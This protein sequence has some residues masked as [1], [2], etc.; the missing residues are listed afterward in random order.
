MRPFY[1][2]VRINPIST[3]LYADSLAIAPAGIEPTLTNGTTAESHRQGRI[4]H[5]SA[6]FTS[7]ANRF[8]KALNIIP[9]FVSS[10]NGD[11]KKPENKHIHK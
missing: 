10:L 4:T 8:T 11:A 7:S 9:V 5:A 6:W 3:I 1:D 2:I